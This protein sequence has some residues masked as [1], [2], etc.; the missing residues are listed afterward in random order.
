MKDIDI[1][2]NSK[3][4]KNLSYDNHLLV[5]NYKFLQV[6]SARLGFVHMPKYAANICKSKIGLYKNTDGANL[7]NSS[8]V[9]SK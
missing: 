8:S 7:V 3:Q 2:V 6:Y 5:G 9:A 1:N 4:P